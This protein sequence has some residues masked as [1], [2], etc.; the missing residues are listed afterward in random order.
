MTAPAPVVAV[1]TTVLYNHSG[2]E[3][4]TAGDAGHGY[5]LLRFL[6]G[7]GRQLQVVD[8]L[9][10]DTS[11]FPGWSMVLDPV[12]CPTAYLPWQGQF[13]GAAVD[14]TLTDAQQ[15][16]QITG[17]GGFARGTPAALVATAQR[18]L[19]G[20]K[21]VVLVERDGDPYTLTV[22]VYAAQVANQSYSSLSAA[23][24]TY[25]QLGAAFVSYTATIGP[26]AELL[27]ALMVAKP[28]GLV[29][30]VNVLSGETYGQL[31]TNYATYT[32]L[33]AAFTTYAAMTN[34]APA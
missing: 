24:P 23:D 1:D 3:A 13:V 27:A 7:I 19:T 22:N 31:S 4:F 10:R 5:P 21:T 34:Q 28:G 8:D 15:R 11:G 20:T 9:C 17:E 18:F 16:A 2:G 25:A 33:T 12:R 6:D 26:A 30:H 29:L 14:T 32:A